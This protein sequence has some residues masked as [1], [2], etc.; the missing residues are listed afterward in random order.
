MFQE[1]GTILGNKI[2][3]SRFRTKISDMDVKSTTKK[4]VV[5][6]F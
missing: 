2:S 6:I 4:S 5:F 3:F 1:K